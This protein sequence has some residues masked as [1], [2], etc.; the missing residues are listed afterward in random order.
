ML[1][2]YG[3]H[4]RALELLLEAK[5]AREERNL[6]GSTALHLA[7]EMDNVAVVT[8]LLAR[9]ADVHATNN[10]RGCRRGRGLSGR[11]RR[12]RRGA[13][14]HAAAVA[15]GVHARHLCSVQWE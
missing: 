7:A 10:V 2:A 11:V 12:A 6:F 4:Q 5:A 1:A 14:S 13:R 9:K 3:G 8:A 15:G